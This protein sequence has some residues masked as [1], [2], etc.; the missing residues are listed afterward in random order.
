MVVISDSGPLISL[1]KIGKFYVLKKI[2]KEIIIPESVYDD[3]Q[4]KGFYL[5][6]EIYQRILEKVR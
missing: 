1:A 4:K 2:F 5:K 3:L 6:E